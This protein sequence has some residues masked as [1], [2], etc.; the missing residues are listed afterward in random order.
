MG[1]FTYSITDNTTRRNEVVNEAVE[2]ANWY[3]NA[4]AEN[5]L[6]EA[7]DMGF[8]EYREGDDCYFLE[9]V[10]DEARRL[11][12]G[13]TW[14]KEI[15]QQEREFDNPHLSISEEAEENEASLDSVIEAYKELIAIR[16]WTISVNMKN[17]ESQ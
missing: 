9:T 3:D 17:K 5:Y 14:I 12:H 10:L 1:D 7:I 2:F 15:M 8:I 13:P 16:D 4:S 11:N 6:D